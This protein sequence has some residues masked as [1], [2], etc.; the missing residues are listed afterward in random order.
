MNFSK[1]II[2]VFVFL[3]IFFFVFGFFFLVYF[4]LFYVEEMGFGLFLVGIIFMIVCLWD[5]FID[6]VFGVFSD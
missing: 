4:F 5:V 6:L 3:G 2:V 1:K